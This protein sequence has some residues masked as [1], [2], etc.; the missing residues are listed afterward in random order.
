MKKITSLVSAGI[1]ALKNKE[2]TL[3]LEKFTKAL[4]L[5]GVKMET[6][7]R[8]SSPSRI[9]NESISDAKE[10]ACFAFSA[11]EHNDVENGIARLEQAISFLL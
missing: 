9:S 1:Q 3:G 4:D 11:L 2:V 8:S 5:L 6:T 10:L 7:K